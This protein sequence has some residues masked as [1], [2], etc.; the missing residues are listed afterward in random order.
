MRSPRCWGVGSPCGGSQD[1]MCE[2]DQENIE[3]GWAMIV[4]RLKAL[5]QLDLLEE[6]A[7]PRDWSKMHDGRPRKIVREDLAGETE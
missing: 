2:V 4:E 7:P 5:G 6:F 3:C 1:G